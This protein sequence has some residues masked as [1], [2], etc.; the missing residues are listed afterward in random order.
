MFFGLSRSICCNLLIACAMACLTVPTSHADQLRTE[1]KS[2]EPGYCEQI[3]ERLLTKENTRCY[4]L[5]VHRHLIKDDQDRPL[6]VMLHGF[7]SKAESITPLISPA[8]EAGYDCAS[9]VYPNDQRIADSAELLSA[10]LKRI[11]RV[12]PERQVSLV[13]Y[14]MGG[15]V[16]RACLE[17][18]AYDPG[19]VKQLI[20]VATPNHGTSL[21]SFAYAGDL[22]EHW[23]ARK[24]GGLWDRTRD[25]IVDGLGE[26]ACDLKPGSEFLSQLNRRPRNPEVEYTLLL[27]AAGPI[28]AKRLDDLRDWLRSTVGRLTSRDTTACV[29]DFQEEYA[30]LVRGT[31]DG[32]VS[33]KR[34]RLAGVEDVVVLP[35]THL[36]VTDSDDSP[37]QAARRVI[38]ER[39]LAVKQ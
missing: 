19:N 33:L 12:Y 10:E 4:G 11:A 35:F 7:N 17:D 24:S 20:L 22:W 13:S 6:V 8:R 38:L 31:G 28:S 30:E 26:A 15:L 21:A 14:S 23:I 39:L 34:G 9:F 16:A 5:H 37:S 36:G 29:D 3:R 18:P 27:G 2:S 25:S 32:V 1:T